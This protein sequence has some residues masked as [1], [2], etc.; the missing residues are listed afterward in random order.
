MPG[1]FDERRQSAPRQTPDQMVQQLIEQT[2]RQSEGLRP[3][4]TIDGFRALDAP[5]GSEAVAKATQ[6]LQRYKAGKAN[7]EQK[8]VQNEQWYKLRHWEILR[9]Q[10][11]DNAG[12]TVEPVSGWLF[13]SLANKHADAMDNFPAPN[14]LPREEGDKAQAEML[15]SIIPVILEQNDFEAVYD[16]AWEYKLKHGTCVYG[17]FWDSS[18][19]NGIGDVSITMVDLLQ[20]FWEPGIK[21]IQKSRNLFHLDLVDNEVLLAQYP[22]LQGNLGSATIETTKYVYDDTVDTSEKSVVVDWYYKKLNA[23]GRQVLH[24]CKY[25]NDMVLFA[26]ENDPNYVDRGLYDHGRYPFEF[27]TLFRMEGTPAGFGYIDIGK[28]AQEYIDRGNQAIMQNMLANTKPR[29]FIRSDGSVN[30]QEYADM[31]NDFIHVDGNLGQD[32]VIPVVGKPLNT[33]YAQVI[34]N[35][36]DEL[37]EVTGNRDISTGG[38]TAGVTAA[39]AIAAMQEAGSKLSRDANKSSYRVFRRICYDVIEL[40][41][42]FYNLPRSFRIMGQNGAAKFIQY[43]NAG[44]IPQQQGIDFGQ[45]MGVRVPMFDVEVTAQKQSPYSKMSQNELA[46]QFY[47]QGFFEPTRADQALACLDM[48]DFDRKDFIAQ[49]I[50]QN[51]GMLQQMMMLAQMVDSMRGG[52]EISAALAQQYGIQMPTAEVDQNAAESNNALGGDEMTGGESSVTRRARQ[53]VADSTTPT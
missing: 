30:E 52:N 8:I 14:V 16:E 39:S 5:I 26:T 33:I 19:L 48:M 40:I 23:Q 18:K 13:N 45:D 20:L 11:K 41:R 38:T 51:G 37:K 17:V 44:I 50:S 34:N 25:V 28:S 29:Y 27:D 43:D 22:Q 9:T 47:N 46:L 6:I 42:Q 7:L 12:S 1:E 36:V 15:T 53:R 3:D 4:G 32:S 31:T 24:Y 35:K 21:D 10:N 49:K 2:R